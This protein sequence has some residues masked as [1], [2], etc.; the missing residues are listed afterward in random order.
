M[1]SLKRKEYLKQ[2]R[3]TNK[4]H[5]SE[6]GRIY[7]ELHKEHAKDY[8]RNYQDTHKEQCREYGRKRYSTN[9]GKLD[10]QVSNA[11]TACLQGEK[12]G[13]KWERFVGYTI[14]DLVKHLEN[15]FDKNMSWENYG[16]YW[17]VDHIKPKSLFQY[18]TPED[19]EFKECWALEN[20]QPLEKNLNMSKSNHYDEN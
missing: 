18:E 8:A 15:L 11:I 17:W 2:Y 1:Q 7:Y 6:V 4:L 16:S 12:A 14:D 20:L 3:Q 10:H 13:K 5:I 19:K 9:M